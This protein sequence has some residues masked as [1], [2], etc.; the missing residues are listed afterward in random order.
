LAS[1]T[2]LGCTL[3]A[4]EPAP[5]GGSGA[6]AASVASPLSGGAPIAGGHG[7]VL[8]FTDYADGCTGVAIN[9]YVVLT[10]AH[11][12]DG[13]LGDALAGDIY[14]SVYSTPDGYSY[15]CENGPTGADGLCEGSHWAYVS[16]YSGP[17]RFNSS[18]PTGAD[19]AVLLLPDAL[20]SGVDLAGVTPVAF[21]SE[22]FNFYGMGV[23]GEGR[24][25]AGTLR[26]FTDRI[27]WVGSKHFFANADRYRMCP[28][29]SG[30]PFLWA[31]FWVFGVAVGGHNSNGGQC[32]G[33]GD[34]QRGRRIT[35]TEINYVNGLIDWWNPGTPHCR[36]VQSDRYWC[37]Y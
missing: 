9:P 3:T 35:K 5:P 7:A 28:G 37:W 20:S 19:F 24:T 30:G 17:S 15:P 34:K 25:D 23:T 12:F 8:I 16:R 6:P 32:T 4:N 27:D 14:T 10:A 18:D 22:G 33:P 21:V 13:A 1:S 26:T 36:E 31:D 11:C 29:D 2:L